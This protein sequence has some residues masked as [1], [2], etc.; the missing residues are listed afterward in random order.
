M[1]KRFMN[2]AVILSLCVAAECK[3]I[4]HSCT[5]KFIDEVLWL[6]SSEKKVRNLNSGWFLL[7]LAVFFFHWIYFL[8]LNVFVCLLEPHYSCILGVFFSLMSVLEL[9]YSQLKPCTENY[10][11]FQH[12]L[13]IPV[14]ELRR[15]D[16]CL[17]FCRKKGL[18]WW[19][20]HDVITVM[21]LSKL[22]SHFDSGIYHFTAKS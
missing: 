19:S 11:T 9:C 1:L 4:K 3:K 13:F 16:A 2:F 20:N 10:K 6:V 7:V 22:F 15:F 21:L 5:R 14:A 17:F 18:W 8:V 12:F